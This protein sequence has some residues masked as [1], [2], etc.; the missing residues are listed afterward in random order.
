MRLPE[1]VLTLVLIGA[2]SASAAAADYYVRPLGGSYGVENGTSYADAFDGFVDVSGLTAGDTLYICG[3]HT[4]E[5]APVNSGAANNHIVADGDCDGDLGSIDTTGIVSNTIDA[6]RLEGR[7]YWTIQNMTVAGRRHG[8][9][10]YSA[11]ARSGFT[12]RNNSIDQRNAGTVTNACHGIM[13]AGGASYA[14]T[15]V[16]IEGNT[17][18]GTKETCAGSFNDAITI[19][20]GTARIYVRDNDLTGSYSGVDLSGASTGEYYITNNRIRHMR[21]NAI[22][23]EGSLGCPSGLTIAGNVGDNLGQWGM[24]FLDIANSLVTHNTFRVFHD[25]PQDGLAPYG[26]VQL[27]GDEACAE[28]GNVFANNIFEANYSAG[29][30]VNYHGTRAAFESGNTWI[31]NRLN[32]SGSQTTL[33]GW[34]EDAGNNVTEANHA[35]WLS[36]HAGE[37]YGD[38]SYVHA[39]CI[40]QG[41]TSTS[42]LRLPPAST[43]RR[44]GTSSVICREARGR[45]CYPDSPDI[46]AYQSTSGDPAATRETAT[47]R[48]AASARQP[49]TTRAARE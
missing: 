4:E 29:V 48:T 39:S 40:S 34:L 6:V 46:G 35:T 41:C 3:A 12:L 9:L 14:Y 36:S 42:D 43:L 22:R 7:S 30:I 23:I 49:A 17:I 2:A 47:T 25:L 24:T 20:K 8:I 21:A 38:V 11:V 33:F 15:D 32:Q 37:T 31:N 19:E 13:F 28:T 45:A 16:I 27:N 26:A 1:C 18:L 10:V 44:T 5:F